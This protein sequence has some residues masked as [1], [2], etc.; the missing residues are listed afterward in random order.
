[1]YESPWVYWCLML[2]KLPVY[3]SLLPT[4]LQISWQHRLLLFF[5]HFSRLY[6]E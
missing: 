4:G 5:I 1:L 3:L 2:T 6:V